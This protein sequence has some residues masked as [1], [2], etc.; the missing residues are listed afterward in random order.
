MGGKW[1]WREWPVWTLAVA[2]LIA[3][4]L[5][6]APWGNYPLND[7]WQYA[8]A[9][10]HYA[11]T[12]LVVIDTPIAPSL[13]GQLV[14]VWPFMKV[15]GFSHVLLRLLTLAMAATMLWA[16]DALLVEW[17]VSR[18]IRLRVLTVLVLNPLFL[19]LSM[20][21]MTECYGYA[22]ALVGAVIWQRSR[23]R[24]DAAATGPA[25][26][27]LGAAVLVGA[28]VGATFWTRQYCVVVFPALVATTIGRL[29]LAREWRRLARSL[30]PLLAGVGAF[31]AAILAYVVWAKH[32]GPLKDA[33]LQPLDQAKDFDLVN[34]EIGGGIQ[35]L[36]LAAYLLPLLVLWPFDRQS[37]RRALAPC[38]VGLG[39]GLTIYSLVQLVGDGDAGPLG[40]H[41]VF[42]FNSNLIHTAG[43][44]PVTLTDVFFLPV[45]PYRVLPRGLW[46]VVGFAAIGASAL[47][48]LPLATALRWRGSSPARS[49]GAVFAALFVALSLAAVIQAYGR[50][51]FDRYD[52][53]LVFGGAFAVAILLAREEQSTA[54][55]VLRRAR[56][57][58]VFVVALAPLTYFTV[59]GMHDYFRWNDA[60][61]RLVAQARSLGVPSTSIDGGYEANGWLSY[62]QVVKHRELLDQSGCI[63]KC[64]CDIPSGLAWIWNCHDD[65][66]RV[67][68]TVRDGYVEVARVQ[69]RFWL[70]SGLP[71][72]LSR[73]PR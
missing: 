34:W 49:E 64:R 15:F 45:D 41:R 11:T 60:R 8:R 52:L 3:V 43:L 37:W 21:F 59:A 31:V 4:T 69:P 27:S 33:F 42:P 68:T 47:V 20:S 67:A 48:G 73:R 40:L 10:R 19:N 2:L 29:V 63:G 23:R 65:S 58:L 46:R 7:D 36:Y 14:M 22:P 71:V 56:F 24:A 17:E 55:P 54:R 26:V 18:E 9:A 12:N 53:P 44:G 16:S 39:F 32:F 66:Y 6:V 62:D 35:L 72:I 61:W 1:I 25:V 51:G 28:L 13:V 5:L 70:G 38:V 57:N 50:F 30:P